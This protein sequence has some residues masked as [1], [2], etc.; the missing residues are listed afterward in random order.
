[1]EDHS[2]ALEPE[3]EEG[4]QENVTAEPN[5]LTTV[6]NHTVSR[7]PGSRDAVNLVLQ[8]LLDLLL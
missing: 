5:S 4:R 6:P 7:H 1:M 2:A 3:S 8:L